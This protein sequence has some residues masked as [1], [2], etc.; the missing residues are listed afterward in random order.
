MPT[1][2]GVVT[3]HHK[4]RHHS[5]AVLDL[6]GLEADAEPGAE[7]GAEAAGAPAVEID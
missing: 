5:A 3:A 2:S 7:P 4:Y 1:V 6:I